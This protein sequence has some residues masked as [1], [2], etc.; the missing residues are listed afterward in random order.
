ME[1]LKDLFDEK[2]LKVIQLFVDAPQKKFFLSDVSKA[3]GVNITTCFRI[4]NKLSEKGFLKTSVL[5]KVR[6]YQLEYN[7]KTKNLMKILNE[8]GDDPGQLFVSYLSSH[9]RTKKI[10]LDSRENKSA[11]IILVGDFIPQERITK[12]VEEIREK[13]NFRISCVEISE[14]QYIK[15][16]EFKDY[17][18]DKKIIWEK[19]SNPSQ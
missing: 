3:S 10:I 6:F 16:K 12:A 2:I 13:H 4:L 7:E 15:F 8:K 18:L 5:G 17:N 11:R 9:P 19:P 1:V 14:S